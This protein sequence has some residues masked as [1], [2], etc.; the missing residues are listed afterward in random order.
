MHRY[1]CVCKYTYAFMCTYVHKHMY[2]H[3]NIKDGY[4]I[5]IL[6]LYYLNVFKNMGYFK[7][8]NSCFHFKTSIQI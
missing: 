6:L 8:K 2:A 1:M 4:V 7:F 5:F 3:Q